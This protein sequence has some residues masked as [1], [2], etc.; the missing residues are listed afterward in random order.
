MKEKDEV[1]PFADILDAVFANETVPIHMLHHFSD[2]AE[3]ET[4]QF[5]ERWATV[6]ADRRQV[7]VRHMADLM[8]QN[9]VVDFSP[10]FVHCFSDEN[11]YVREAALD[12]VWDATDIKMVSPIIHLMQTD[13]NVAVRAA[14]SRAL[15]HYVLLAEWGQ[16]PKRI[17]PRIIEALLAEYDKED[18]AVPIKRA[19]LEALGAANHPRVVQLIEEAYEDIDPSMQISAIFAMG[20]SADKRWTAFVIAEME[21]PNP[22]MRAE[23]A[24]AAGIIGGSDAVPRLSELAV[25]EDLAVQTAA[26]YSLGQ[27][28]GETAQ[29]TLT[30]LLADED[31][32]EIHDII[33]EALEEMAMLNGELDIFDYMENDPDDTDDPYLL[34]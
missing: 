28:G 10:I 18:T 17:T 34:N 20:S 11:A 23:A 25:D 30:E 19:T 1:I 8:E 6:D 21:N 22:D 31:F 27:I 12:G 9:F 3:D 16:L 5:Q 32:E 15:A 7:V 13:E 4:S 33:E 14:A 2:M 29:T 26:I 24:R